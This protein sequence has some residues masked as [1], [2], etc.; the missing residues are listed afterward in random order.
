MCRREDKA[1]MYS[2]Q[3]NNNNKGSKIIA[4]CSNQNELKIQTAQQYNIDKSIAI[5]APSWN[6]GDRATGI[7]VHHS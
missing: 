4:D 2:G 5:V 6:V 7:N 1:V 3:N